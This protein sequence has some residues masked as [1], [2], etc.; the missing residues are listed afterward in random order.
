[1]YEFFRNKLKIIGIDENGYGPL[2]GPLIITG[3]KIELEGEDPLIETE[4]AQFKT[5][6]TLK[7]S[8]YIFN[9]SG[10]S[11]KRGEQI[12]FELL[13]IMDI[14]AR[15]FQ[16]LLDLISINEIN[17]QE[18]NLK[19]FKIPT[20]QDKLTKTEFSNYWKKAGFFFKDVKI[21]V[22]MPDR[23]NREIEQFNNKS[24]VDFKGFME[25]ANQ[26][27]YEDEYYVL[28]GKIGGTE[29]YSRF[30]KALNLNF[31]IIKERRVYSEYLLN[32]R[33]HVYFLLN[34]DE[35]YL[36]IMLASIIGKYIR[37]LFMLALS[38]KLGFNTEIPYASGYRHDQKTYELLKML[39]HDDKKKWVRIR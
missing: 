25:V 4:V 33:H 23:F 21:N 13:D 1:M 20:F 29:H 6:F 11:Y 3:I 10:H 32:G 36:P 31:K 5:P 8:K 34:G 19:D 18:Y 37:E 2:L 14:K 7:D 15:T 17:I 30:F 27:I 9:R 28:C 16:E 12:V 26:L 38:R 39:N 22:I 35:M 24:I